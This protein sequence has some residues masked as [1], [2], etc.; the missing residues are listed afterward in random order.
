MKYLMA[1]I[2]L[3][4][5]ATPKHWVRFIVVINVLPFLSMMMYKNGDRAEIMWEA[6]WFGHEMNL[7]LAGIIVVLVLLFWLFKND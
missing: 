1:F 3:I 7:I 5:E 2:K 4:R 6:Y